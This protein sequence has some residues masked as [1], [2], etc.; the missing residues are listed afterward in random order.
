VLV[1]SYLH[2]TN[3]RHPRVM[4][5]GDVVDFGPVSLRL[6]VIEP[7][8]PLNK[9]QLS[10]KDNATNALLLNHGMVPRLQAIQVKTPCGSLT[11]AATRVWES[12]RTP[13]EV[14]VSFF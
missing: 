3:A 11:V 5:V 14:T 9:Y 13:L 1:H 6:D 2:K 4:N 10:V 7:G 12:S 8:E